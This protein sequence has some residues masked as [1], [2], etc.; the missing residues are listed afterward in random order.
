LDIKFILMREIEL[1]TFWRTVLLL[2]K[3]L[4]MRWSLKA[5]KNYRKIF[6]FT[7]PA[8]R[9]GSQIELSCFFFCYW[10]VLLSFLQFSL[11]WQGLTIVK[12]KYW[13]LEY[14]LVMKYMIL[15]CFIIQIFSKTKPYQISN[16]I[17]TFLTK[18]INVERKKTLFLLGIWDQ[19]L[20]ITTI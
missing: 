18:R 6:K 11:L 14:I 12:A 8:L 17:T 10:F 15:R 5:K 2:R 13:N 19:Y 4:K 20:N 16:K 3:N 9:V 1:S 7:I